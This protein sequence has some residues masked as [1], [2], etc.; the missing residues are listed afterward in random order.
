MS[1]ELSI[2][3]KLRHNAEL[4]ISV[5][6][7]RLGVELAFDHAGVQWVDGYI[8]RLRESFPVEKRPAIIDRLGAFVGECI[9]S[10]YGGEWVEQDGSWGVQVSP[11]LWACPFAKIDKQF[12]NGP[13]DSV[14]S[15][16]TAIP[17]INE[18][19]RHESG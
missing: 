9:I 15:F 18:H 11:S 1:G 17:I 2:P 12:E 13:E 8:E 14:E 7:D 3:E 16:F 10:T 19:R 6:R 5:G 4:V